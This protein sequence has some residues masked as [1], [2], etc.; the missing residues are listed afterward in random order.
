MSLCSEYNSNVILERMIKK[1]IEEIIMVDKW[2]VSFEL[3]I[4]I[5]TIKMIDDEKM[6]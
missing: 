6:V 4:R 5:R 2:K 1:S 3:E